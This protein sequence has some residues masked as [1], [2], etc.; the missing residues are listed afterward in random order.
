MNVI[1][2]EKIQGIAQ[3][4]IVEFAEMNTELA[5]QVSQQHISD[6]NSCVL[7]EIRENARLLLDLINQNYV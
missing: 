2:T 6:V 7:R 5:N 1:D 3:N 4:L